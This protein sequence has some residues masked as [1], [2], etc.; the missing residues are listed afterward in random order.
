MSSFPFS[1]FSS[2]CFDPL[3]TLTCSHYM[4]LIESFDID[5]QDRK[6]AGRH[7]RWDVK[8]CPERQLSGISMLFNHLHAQQ[9]NRSLL[10]DQTYMYLR[11]CPFAPQNAHNSSRCIHHSLWNRI[12]STAKVFALYSFHFSDGL[13]APEHPVSACVALRRACQPHLSNGGVFVCS[14]RQRLLTFRHSPNAGKSALSRSLCAL[15][16]RLCEL[17]KS[18]AGSRNDP[19]RTS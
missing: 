17:R 5:E 19:L 6:T 18:Q 8:S 13:L 12:G 7:Y 1:L 10:L 14:S 4:L 11:P 15:V 16:A 2:S 3:P 9:L